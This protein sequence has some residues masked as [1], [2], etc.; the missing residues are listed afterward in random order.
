MEPVD[1]QLNEAATLSV[2]PPSPWAS[3]TA[4]V[5]TRA[6]VSV[7]TPTATPSAVDTTVDG[8]GVSPSIFSVAVSTG[9]ARGLTLQVNDPQFGIADSVVASINGKE[10]K[11]VTPLPVAPSDGATVKGLDVSV[12]LDAETYTAALGLSFVLEVKQ[13]GV[14][15]R[16]VF[17][18]C[19]YPFVG[20]MTEEM[21]REHMTRHWPGERSVHAAEWC[22]RVAD[23]VNRFLR[24][25]LLE[26][27]AYISEFW[28]PNALEEV[29]FILLDLVLF[30]RGYR[31]P[32]TN[33]DEFYRSTDIQ[34]ER[35]IGAL[36][37]S[38]T[39]RDIDRDGIIDDDE[40][41]GDATSVLVR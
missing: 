38:A 10:V 2:V 28:N 26:S 11:L 4:E 15:R 3:P 5:K 37:K 36:L 6:G 33:P 7:G 13:S 20:P 1:L 27:D 25:R 18:V 22:Q 8:G 9:I 40:L 35:R 30:R 34:L 17:N 23:Q 31:M 41:D 19:T 16:R 12:A 24:G 39:P 32:G 29:S 21:V 14:A